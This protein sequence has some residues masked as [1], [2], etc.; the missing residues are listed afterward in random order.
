MFE[1]LKKKFSETVGKITEK[2]SSGQEPRSEE[3][4]SEDRVPE[5][6]PEGKPEEEVRTEEPDDTSSEEPSPGAGEGVQVSSHF[7]GKK[8]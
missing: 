5:S 2:V 4:K 1:S 7:S 8:G 6:I 3:D